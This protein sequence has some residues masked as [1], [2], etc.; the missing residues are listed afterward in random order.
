M[1]LTHEGCAHTLDEQTSK[2]KMTN[3]GVAF[4]TTSHYNGI[5]AHAQNAWTSQCKVTC[6]GKG[7]DTKR[8]YGGVHGWEKKVRMPS[9]PLTKC[10]A[11][12]PRLM[13]GYASDISSPSPH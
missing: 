2:H 11:C 8:H 9:I 13:F 12:L 3:V 6:L 10:F 7:V 1:P 4:D 5:H